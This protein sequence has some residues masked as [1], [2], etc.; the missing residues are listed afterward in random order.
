MKKTGRK[1][2]PLENPPS[3]H[4]QPTAR[5]RHVQAYPPGGGTRGRAAR[6]PPVR[7]TRF[8]L[9]KRGVSCG[10]GPQLTCA[11][12][13]LISALP[14]CGDGKCGK[15]VRASP[16][17]LRVRFLR[18]S[19]RGI[20]PAARRLAGCGTLVRSSVSRAPPTWAEGQP[21]AAWG[22]RGSPLAVSF[23]YFLSVQ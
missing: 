14:A 13:N 4:V 11:G 1:L 5:R 3:A 6:P 12:L 22:S 2:A 18:L 19:G 7:R 16:N 21:E 15:I 10:R 20:A 9:S 17:A 8:C 23:P